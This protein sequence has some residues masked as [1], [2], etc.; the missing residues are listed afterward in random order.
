MIEPKQ[1]KKTDADEEPALDEAKKQELLASLNALDDSSGYE[2]S[3]IGSSITPPRQ[4]ES[5]LMYHTAANNDTF[6]SSAFKSLD[7][8]INSVKSSL[9][10]D[11]DKKAK[12]MQEL[13]SHQ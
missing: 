7:S 13:F 5:R 1:Y 9:S 6:N 10:V 11:S 4:Q 3:F 2:P 12:L 8:S